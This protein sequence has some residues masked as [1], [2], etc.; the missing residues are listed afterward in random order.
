MT[1]VTVAQLLFVPWDISEVRAEAT[2]LV[3][4]IV[5]WRKHMED[6]GHGEVMLLEDLHACCIGCRDL[7]P[8]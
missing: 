6:L 5:Q 7:D 1:N 3:G 2:E 8:V 4:M